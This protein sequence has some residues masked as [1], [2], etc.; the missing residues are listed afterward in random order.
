MASKPARSLVSVYTPFLRRFTDERALE[1]A[2]TIALYRSV[3]ASWRAS[4]WADAEA[5]ERVSNQLASDVIDQVGL[6]ESRALCE[7]LDRC[8]REVIA[9]ETTIFSCPEITWD[10]A[11]LSLKEQVDLRRFLRA[12]E[13]FLANEQRVSELFERWLLSL[14]CGLTEEFPSLPEDDSAFSVPLL[15]MLPNPGQVVARIMGTLDRDELRDAGLF[16]TLQD[17]FYRNVCHASGVLP[18]AEHRKPLV[19]A[20]ASDLPPRELIE[21]YLANTPF[22]DLLLTPVPFAIPRQSRFEHMHIVAGSGHGKTQTLQHL[23]FSDLTADEPPAIVVIDSQGDLIKKISHL[24]L[25]DPYDGALAEKL[26]I[27]DPTDVEYPPALNIF[28]VGAERMRGY[29]TAAREQVLNGVIELYDYLF[30]SLLGSELTQK[31][32]VIFR[33]LARLMLTIP[34]ATIL[35]LLNLMT[36]AEPY[37]PYIQSLPSGARAFFK[38]EFS[39]RS[40]AQTKKQIQ[41]RLWGVLENP[42]FERMFTAPKNR[43]DM[44]DALNNGKIVLV[45]TAKDFLKAERSSFLGRFFISLTL[46][47]VLERAVI[48][49][50][51]RRPA[52]LYIDEAAEYFDDNIDDLLSQARKYSLGVVFAHQYLDQL[53]PGL[54]ASIAANASVKLAGGVST[55][56]ARSL[57]PDMRTTPD[58]LL[59]QHKGTQSTS[60][61]CYVRNLTSTAISLTVPFGTLEQQP[62]MDEVYFD[63]L[64]AENRARLSV[65]ATPTEPSAQS[66]A[67]AAKPAAPPTPEVAP[68]QSLQEEAAEIEEPAP[69]R[70]RP[71][72]E[73]DVVSEE[74]SAALEKPVSSPPPKPKPRKQPAV[75][76]T[77]GR[78][79]R[80]HKYL[81]HLLQGAAQQRGYHAVIEAATV[82]GAGQ[83]DLLLTKGKLKIACEITVTTGKHWE[84]GNVKKCLAAGY[85]AVILV[86]AEERH[87][88]SLGT[89]VTDQLDIEE[90]RRVHYLTPDGVISYLDEL[91]IGTETTEETVR[92]YKVKVSRAAVDPDEMKTRREAIAKVLAKSMKKEKTRSTPSSEYQE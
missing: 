2:D 8:Q 25:F 43:I 49:E 37:A 55:A 52:F 22:R 89:F 4:R 30:G 31:Q 67:F 50:A 91:N 81:Q 27:I 59:G 63:S 74:P 11:N 64:I 5:V 42:T 41:R 39:D 28:D 23:L 54:R 51:Q 72:S 69:E 80:Q 73:A 71:E 48:P 88:K 47:A 84:L 85:D 19:L 92:G 79:G 20:D 65:L 36:D 46:Q 17:Q 38:S 78:G 90:R 75:G 83:I 15:S 66:E 1:L 45:N 76:A 21:T 24:E 14:F 7:A 56:D 82:D 9:L 40:F 57:A 35:D 6:P 53:A 33:Y 26:I 12:Q 32:S 58:F 13:H 61:A 34:G 62:T 87:L 86:S 60:F 77:L 18:E 68:E 29:G 70:P 3:R 10:R 44:F 16:T